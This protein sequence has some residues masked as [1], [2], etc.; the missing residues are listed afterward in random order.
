MAKRRACR[1][2]NLECQGCGGKGA[3]KHKDWGF[4]VCRVCR[5]VGFNLFVQ[6]MDELNRIVVGR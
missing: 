2:I 5:A 1:S 3:Q 4:L 6:F